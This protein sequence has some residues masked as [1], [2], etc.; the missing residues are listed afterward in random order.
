MTS[1]AGDSKESLRFKRQ[2][3]TR[4]LFLSLLMLAITASCFYFHS[5]SYW[6]PMACSSIAEKLV[7]G[8]WL[9]LVFYKILPFQYFAKSAYD[10]TAITDIWLPHWSLRHSLVSSSLFYYPPPPSII[11]HTALIIPSFI[12]LPLQQG[13]ELNILLLRI[14]QPIPW[15]HG[16]ILNV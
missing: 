1:E 3:L 14:N 9:L 16:H 15:T 6:L 8:F 13:L 4:V 7:L 10:F 5:N 12:K 2:S 11:C